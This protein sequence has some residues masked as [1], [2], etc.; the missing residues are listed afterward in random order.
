MGE[1][2]E[3]SKGLGNEA[4]GNLKQATADM[5]DDASLDAK[6]KRQE[7]KGEAQQVAGEIE[8]ELGNDI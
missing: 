4:M 1:L 2:K 6:G 7:A 5:T 8:G 3:K